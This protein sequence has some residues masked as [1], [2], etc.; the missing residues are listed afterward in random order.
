[1]VSPLYD[2]KHVPQTPARKPFL[3]A[4]YIVVFPKSRRT[5]HSIIHKFDH[6]QMT[7]FDAEIV[8]NTPLILT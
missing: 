6:G 1:M 8:V 3:E 2:D 5:M 7:M 4:L